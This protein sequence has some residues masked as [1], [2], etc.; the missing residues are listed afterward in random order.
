MVLVTRK[1]QITIPKRVREEL[2][3][4]A[5]DEVVFIKTEDGYKI[6]RADDVIKEGVEIFKD[7]DETI[8]EM[9]AGLQEGFD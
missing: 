7:I 8:E 3:I 9:K 4:K 2:N 5:G 6:V 1:Y